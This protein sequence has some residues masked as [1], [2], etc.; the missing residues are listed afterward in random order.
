MDFLKN[1][2]DISW[3]DRFLPLFKDLFMSGF[4][5]VA[6]LFRQKA[7][8]NVKN[9]SAFKLI[10]KNKSALKPTRKLLPRKKNGLQGTKE[11]GLKSLLY[12][13]DPRAT[14][15]VLVWKTF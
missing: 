15:G 3:I 6:R 12:P 10:S 13:R 11:N 7:G 1:A 9:S 14:L 8:L 2:E 4:L 5:R